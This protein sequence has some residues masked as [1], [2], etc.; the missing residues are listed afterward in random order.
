MIW[1]SDLQ[2]IFFI[3][4]NYIVHYK[5]MIS[6]VKM[7]SNFWNLFCHI[8][9]SENGK[10]LKKFWILKN[11]F[12]VSK[13]WKEFSHTELISACSDIRKSNLQYPEIIIFSY[14]AKKNILNNISYWKI[15]IFFHVQKLFSNKKCYIPIWEIQSNIE[16]LLS[17]FLILEN[18]LLYSAIFQHLNMIN[19]FWVLVLKCFLSCHDNVNTKSWWWWWRVTEIYLYDSKFDT[20]GLFY[21]LGLT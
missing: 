2:Q 11:D 21:W 3:I 1:I 14:I 8:P 4:E 7:I 5:E 13:K 12:L 18:F 16:K 9:L 10:N 17:Q 15:C 19:L 6:V 20:M